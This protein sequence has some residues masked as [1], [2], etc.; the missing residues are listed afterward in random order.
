MLEVHCE[1]YIY[2]SACLGYM[3]GV[4][5][6]KVRLSFIYTQVLTQGNYGDIHE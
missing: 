6:W 5:T 4:L 1:G 2:V 3:N